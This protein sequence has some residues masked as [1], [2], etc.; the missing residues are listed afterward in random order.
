MES[1]FVRRRRCRRRRRRRRRVVK[2]N[3][4]KYLLLGVHSDERSA[5]GRRFGL[6]L[7]AVAVTVKLRV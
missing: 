6:A 7:A 2:V 4:G 1:L 5:L 3:L